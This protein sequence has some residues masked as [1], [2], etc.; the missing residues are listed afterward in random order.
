MTLMSPRTGPRAQGH[1]SLARWLRDTLGSATGL[2]S[3]DTA[4]QGR[5]LGVSPCPEPARGL[6]SQQPHL[7]LVKHKPEQNLGI[8]IS[9]SQRGAPDF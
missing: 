3:R 4:T 8:P 9:N 2:E 7:Q 1:P 6:C 5:G